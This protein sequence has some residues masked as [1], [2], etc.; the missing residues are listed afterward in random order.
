MENID[1]KAA[2]GNLL[3]FACIQMY[4]EKMEENW[5]LLMKTKK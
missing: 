5:V 1:I 4:T 2:G 3:L